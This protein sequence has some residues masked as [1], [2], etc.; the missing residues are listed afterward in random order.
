[1]KQAILNYL[2]HGI[3]YPEWRFARQPGY[4]R[5][6]TQIRPTYIVI[7]AP[8]RQNNK[9]VLKEDAGLLDLTLQ[10]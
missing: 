3:S 4:V 5:Y 1:M 6:N 7:Y 8:M 10:K 2:R 9:N